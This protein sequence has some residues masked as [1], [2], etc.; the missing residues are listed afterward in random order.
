VTCRVRSLCAAVRGLGAQERRDVLG[1]DV[2]VVVRGP[3][4]LPACLPA[5]RWAG[6]DGHLSAKAEPFRSWAAHL[7]SSGAQAALVADSPYYK[8]LIGRVLGYQEDNIRHHIQVGRR[9]SSVG[10]CGQ[11][12]APGAT[13][14]SG[15][16]RHPRG[17][18]PAASGGDG[19]AGSSC[20]GL[21]C[22]GH[23]K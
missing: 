12:G 23:R 8:L 15:S 9:S 6:P 20:G 17:A 14:V 21:R 13:A 2:A 7:A 4:Q 18:L 11:A 5:C 19:C 1:C 10:I 16:R 3:N 22:A